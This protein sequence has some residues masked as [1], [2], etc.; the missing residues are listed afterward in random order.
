MKRMLLRNCFREIHKARNRFL[1]ILAI[2]ALGVGFF[3]GIRSTSPDMR[4]GADQYYDEH[5]LMDVKLLSSLG[6]TQADQEALCAL[7]RWNRLS[8]LTAATQLFPMGEKNVV[9]KVM[10]LSKDWEEGINVPWLL[11]GRMPESPGECIV[12][13]ADFVGEAFSLGSTVTLQS[14]NP[15]KPISDT[16]LRETYT[17]VG[18]FKSPMYVSFDK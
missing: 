3:A 16:F 12:D 11:E 13:K 10:G 1:S 17:V 2:T 18:F 6:F 8:F 14:G 7:Q 5:R 9:I 15:D 4:L